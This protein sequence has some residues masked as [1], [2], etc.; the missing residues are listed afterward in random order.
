MKLSKTLIIIVILICTILISFLLPKAKYTGTGFISKLQM[1]DQFSEWKGRDISEEVGLRLNSEAFNFISE[2]LA[3]QYVNRKGETLLFIILDAGN[4]H[5]P[6]VC[7]TGAGYK[8][9]DLPA[10]RFDLTGRSI[11]AHTLHTRRGKNRFLSFYWIIIDKNI[12]HQWIEQKLKQLF[13]SL[14]GKKRV[15]LMVRIDIPAGEHDI[16]KATTLAK[17]FL[18]DLSQSLKTDQAEYIFGEERD[19]LVKK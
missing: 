4:F 12:A 10:T 17:N 7:F 1:P 18:N 3:Y 2:A 6:K 8:I 19:N 16:E 5:H 9:K 13:F 15:G 14:F 11:I